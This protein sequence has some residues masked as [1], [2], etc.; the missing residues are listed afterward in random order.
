MGGIA[1][2][3]P[4]I[5][6]GITNTSSVGGDTVSDALDTLAAVVGLS[7][8][9]AVAASPYAVKAS[10]THIVLTGTGQTVD[11]IAGASH[12]TKVLTIKAPAN[13]GASPVTIDANGAETIDGAGT[14][15]LGAYE[16][17]TLVFSG[18]EWSVT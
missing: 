10:D 5:S 1:P 3:R 12:G 4:A 8:I 13:A 17:V 6:S 15:A 7:P 18:T 14:A 2:Y 11:L 16:A 9:T